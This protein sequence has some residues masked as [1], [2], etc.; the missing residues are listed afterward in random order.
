MSAAHVVVSRFE[1]LFL[2][3]DQ[4][5]DIMIETNTLTTSTS[6]IA[7]NNCLYSRAHSLERC[8]S[9]L[10]TIQRFVRVHPDQTK[11]FL[12]NSNALLMWN[13]F[14]DALRIHTRSVLSTSLQANI[15]CRLRPRIHLLVSTTAH[16]LQESLELFLLSR[17]SNSAVHI[18]CR[19][20]LQ[21]AV[22]DMYVF[23]KYMRP[24]RYRRLA[25]SCT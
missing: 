2:A 25:P 9:L 11:W 19:R 4:T 12:V 17:P 1:S 6:T 23:V 10:G 24:C 15:F 7:D 18:K 13:V 14:V 21:P 22:V 3:A 20:L 16:N 5:I 8:L